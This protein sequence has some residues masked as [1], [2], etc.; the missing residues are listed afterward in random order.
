MTFGVLL[1]QMC[2][3]EKPQ[4]VDTPDLPVLL[5]VCHISLILNKT[6]TNPL[7]ISCFLLSHSFQSSCD[8]RGCRFFSSFAH[9]RLRRGIHPSDFCIRLAYLPPGPLNQSLRPVASTSNRGPKPLSIYSVPTDPL[10]QWPVLAGH[11]KR[12]PN[13]FSPR[14]YTRLP[15]TLVH[16]KSDIFLKTEIER[17]QSPSEKTSLHA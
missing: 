12:T 1:T 13:L 6:T 17:Q 9:G 11:P 5:Y 7:L 3:C 2:Q 4:P 15:L 16:S 14:V 10:S 8:Q